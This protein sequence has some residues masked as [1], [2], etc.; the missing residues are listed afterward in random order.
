MADDPESDR[1]TSAGAGSSSRI[2]TH[3][4]PCP[5]PLTPA[6]EDDHG[7]LRV[8]APAT[9]ATV[10]NLRRALRDW[11]AARG[12]ERDDAEDVVLLV[13][14]AVTNA[15]EHAC[16]DHDACRVEVVAT[17]RPCGAGIAVLIGDDGHWRPRPADPGHRGRGVELMGRLADRS[18]ILTDQHGTTVQM[19]WLPPRDPGR[20]DG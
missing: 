20:H 4:P 8:S 15:V 19:C 12:V 16:T 6:Q 18:S 1:P 17:D 2:A 13:D 5:C 3:G 10:Q 9:P 14:E 7:T 11:L